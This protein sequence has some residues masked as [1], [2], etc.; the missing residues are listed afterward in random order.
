MTV[1]RPFYV[2]A[3][4][5]GTLVPWFFFAR[6]FATEGFDLPLFVEQLFALDPAAGFSSDVLIS[7][8][9]F[10]PWSFLDARR[11]GVPHWWLVVP[12]SFLVGLSLSL[13]LYLLLRTFA[14][15]PDT[16]AGAR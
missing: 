6:F 14:R 7:I 4:V 11:T 1:E 16:V 15:R 13:P 5:V 8:A 12:A 3:A 9:V 2:A 10:L